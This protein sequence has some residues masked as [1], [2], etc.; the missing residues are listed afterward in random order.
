MSW[1]RVHNWAMRPLASPYPFPFPSTKPPGTGAGTTAPQ[2]S[3]SGCHQSPRPCSVDRDGLQPWPQWQGVRDGVVAGAVTG[4]C[5][6]AKTRPPSSRLSPRRNP[7][8]CCPPIPRS[9]S[10][11]AEFCLGPDDRSSALSKGGEDP[12]SDEWR[13]HGRAK[14]N[15]HQARSGTRPHRYRAEVSARRIFLLE[16]LR[17]ASLHRRQAR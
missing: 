10:P 1:S 4:R 3:R 13:P 17:A 15:H 12:G 9:V 6:L 2:L 11:A 16:A 14:H 8:V 5:P 7:N